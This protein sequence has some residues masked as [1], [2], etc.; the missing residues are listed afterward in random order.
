[1]YISNQ[2]NG[3]VINR[4]EIFFGE[5]AIAPANAGNEQLIAAHEPGLFQNGFFASGNVHLGNLFVVMG[6][7]A[8]VQ[9]NRHNAVGG[10]Q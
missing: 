10:E 1:M 9:L 3:M 7:C 6:V 8:I 2:A 4:V 5:K